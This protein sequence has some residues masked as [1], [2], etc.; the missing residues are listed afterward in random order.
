[1]TPNDCKKRQC[2][3]HAVY[4]E[5]DVCVLYQVGENEEEQQL[6]ALDVFNVSCKQC[7][8]LREEIREWME[9][10]ENKRFSEPKNVAVEKI[11]SDLSQS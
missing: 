2:P 11:E 9:R 1:M 7:K 5:K 4:H 8:R 3:R 6:A 10:E